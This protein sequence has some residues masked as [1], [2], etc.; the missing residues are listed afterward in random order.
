MPSPTEL[1]NS[2]IP[3]SRQR[4]YKAW[5]HSGLHLIRQGPTRDARLLPA[6]PASLHA[7]LRPT[8]ARA[9]GG[10]VV[11]V[12]AEEGIAASAALMAANE[13]LFASIL[14]RKP[15]EDERD[16]AMIEAGTADRELFWRFSSCSTVSFPMEDGT[17]EITL[18]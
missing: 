10:F 4:T 3:V 18:P 13:M 9:A 11:A 1:F 2:P 17:D 5:A 6:L 8:S 16:A 15:D 14:K 7:G 12:P